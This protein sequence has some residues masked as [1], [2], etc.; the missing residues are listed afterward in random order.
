MERHAHPGEFL[1][2]AWLNVMGMLGLSCYIL[3]DTFFIARALGA[4]GLAALNL[5]LPVYSLVHGSGLMLGVGGATRYSIFRGQGLPP[6]EERTFSH[7]LDLALALAGVCLCAGLF[8]SPAITALLGGRGAVGE[9]TRIYLQVILLFSPAFLLNDILLCY[10]RNDGS[11][12]LAMAAMLTGSASNVLLDYLFL[13]PLGMGIFGAV[14]ATGLAALISIAVLSPRLLRRPRPFRW[15]RERRSGAMYL[16]LLALGVPSLVTEASSGIVIMAFNTIFLRLEGNT[17]VAA[18]GVVA[19]LSLVV[20]AIFTGLAQGGQPIISRAWGGGDFLRVRHT[21]AWACAAALVLSALLF[22]LL[23]L[24][25]SPI[26]A[27]F[28]S[29]GDP[30]LQ[31][32]AVEGI[33]LYFIGLPFVGLNTVLV[34]YFTSTQRPAPAQLLSLCRGFFLLLPAAVLL[35]LAWGIP[36]V[37][38]SYPL[39]EALVTLLAL[40]LRPGLLPLGKKR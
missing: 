22:S 2:Y 29:Q 28:N 38:L 31:R 16:D 18:Y 26:A 35:A 4:D 19:N 17:S 21:G 30:A 25:A 15:V 13:F 10:V 14:L 33:R 8:L 12:R 32:I 1:R 37:W 5:A 6:G 20:S 27:L 24:F 34:M 7:T 11:P 23:F 40:F 9:M 36:G 3:A 39:T